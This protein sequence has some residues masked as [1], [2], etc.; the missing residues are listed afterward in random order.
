MLNAH[1]ATDFIQ[2]DTTRSTRALVRL[3]PKQLPGRLTV[4]AID[5]RLIQLHQSHPHSLSSV[6]R[7]A[8]RSIAALVASFSLAAIP[9]YAE[10]DWYPSRY[11]AEDTLG[12]ANLLTP[13]L[14]VR[15]AKLVKTGKTYALGVPTGPAT[16]AYGTRTYQIMTTGGDST[17]ATLGT[18][19]ATY[20]DDLLIT[21]LGIGSQLDGLG[22]LGIGHRYYNGVHASEFVQLDGLKKFSTHLVPPIVTRGVLID[23]AA[24]QGESMLPIETA[25]N[26]PQIKA[27]LA[28]QG[29]MTIR[30]G[31]VVLLHTGWQRLASSDATKFLSGEPGLGVAG[32]EYLAK[33]G[34]VAVGA[35]T[36]GIEILPPEDKAQ[37]FPVHQIMLAKHGVYLL[38]NM[39]TSALARDKAYEFLFVLGQP[40]FVG[41]VQA[42]INPIAI[43]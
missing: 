10:D 14:V 41:S 5:P 2:H 13:D 16:P 36:W 29:N 27:A 21:W 34:A 11:G 26:P 17:G 6:C 32:A 35:D 38:E 22:H 4:L 3:G 8:H 42:V 15:A 7:M 40:R 1:N 18:N 19:E 43:R 31:D 39:D 37:A 20:N 9:V 24:L 28:R 30:Q 23:V 25:I 12:A 33:L